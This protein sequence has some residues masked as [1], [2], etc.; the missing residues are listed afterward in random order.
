MN[1][2]AIFPICQIGKD[3]LS[4]YH[5]LTVSTGVPLEGWDEKAI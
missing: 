2:K 3:G 5:F 1:K 4:F